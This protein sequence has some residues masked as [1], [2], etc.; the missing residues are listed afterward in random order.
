M[1]NTMKTFA[2]IPR[3]PR[4]MVVK[5]ASSEIPWTLIIWTIYGRMANMPENCI[6]RNNIVINVK[7]LSVR[8]LVMSLS[9]S[10]NVGGAWSH[11]LPDFSHS[12]HEVDI[13]PMFFNCLN[14]AEMLSVDTHPRSTWSDFCASS[15]RCLE[16]N[17]IGASGT[18]NE[19][20][21]NYG[22]ELWT[23]A[24]VK[25]YLQTEPPKCWASEW[26]R[27]HKPHD[28]MTWTTPIGRSWKCRQLK[29]SQRR[30]SRCH[31]VKAHCKETTKKF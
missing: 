12:E 24:L 30:H 4:R 20:R 19:N 15:E 6:M 17:Q 8:F 22:T 5:L 13:S 1:V 28:A 9:L 25:C 10:D 3:T 18:L 2:K 16:I 29:L 11:L 26:V 21:Y 23:N 14:S 31:E 27:M 7:G